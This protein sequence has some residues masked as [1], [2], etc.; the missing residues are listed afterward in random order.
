MIELPKN[1]RL[2]TATAE[3][4]EDGTE[5]R[6][7]V[8][9]IVNDKT[10]TVSLHFTFYGICGRNGEDTVI[11]EEPLPPNVTYDF[12]AATT[13]VTIQNATGTWEGLS[14]DATASGAKLAVREGNWAQ[15]NEGCI[16]KVPVAQECLITVTNYDT[17]YSVDGVQAAEKEQS[18]KVTKGGDVVIKATANSYIGSI[19]V[20][21]DLV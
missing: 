16:I 17:N 9:E 4:V 21:Y 2:L 14:V 1:C 18:F 20:R 7:E 12:K 5:R 8:S 13:A 3:I 19:S 10:G 11:T 6:C 15:F